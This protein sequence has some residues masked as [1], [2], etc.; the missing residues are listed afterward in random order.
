MLEFLSLALIWLYSLDHV[1]SGYVECPR[2]KPC[3]FLGKDFGWQVWEES[4]SFSLQIPPVNDNWKK[5]NTK[6]FL[7]ISSYRD[8]LCP[9]TLYNLYHKS[10]FPDRVFAGVVQQNDDTVDLDCFYTYCKLVNERD[11]KN[12]TL[13]ECPYANNI[14][15]TRIHAKEAKGPTWARAKGMTMLDDEEF[16]MQTDS[17]MDFEPRW[18]SK[19]LAM[20]A[21]TGNEYAVLST[22][23]SDLAQYE[24]NMDGKKGVNGAFEVPNLCMITLGGMWGMPRV[25]ATKCLR[26][27][28]KPKLTNAVWG[29]GLSFS[30]CHAERKVPYDPH[31]PHIFD[32]EEFSR[33]IR[34]WTH[35]YDIYT[36]HRVYI[37][38]NYKD[39]QVKA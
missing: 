24:D 17:H 35:G 9:I 37:L 39:S 10:E 6:I 12:Y 14:R 5:S 26:L 23:V 25:H 34:F 30:K 1:A 11:N 19:M 20:W 16:C 27:M 2:G 3:S 36:P 28:P 32:G 21:D 38:H 15:M 7:A 18:D 8:K 4:D 33:A 22:Y 29:A 13:S 31:T